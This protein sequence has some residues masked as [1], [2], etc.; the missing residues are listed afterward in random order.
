M[1]WGPRFQFMS[2]TKLTPAP[3]REN[4]TEVASCSS[5]SPPIHPSI[6]SFSVF[7]QPLEITAKAQRP[8][9]WRRDVGVERKRELPK[10]RRNKREWK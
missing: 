2:P 5:I 8:E 9:G 7:S 4:F 1:N 6:L 3:W 10:G